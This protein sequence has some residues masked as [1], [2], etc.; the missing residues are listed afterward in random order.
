M[1]P[2]GTIRQRAALGL[3]FALLQANT[4]PITWRL[5]RIWQ[6]SGAPHCSSSRRTTQP[7]AFDFAENE[8]RQRGHVSRLGRVLRK[9]PV[10]LPP[11]NRQYP[12]PP[13]CDSVWRRGG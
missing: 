8:A 9:M 13:E 2:E 11:Q 10:R 3:R 1:F 12:R 6:Q 4:G 5:A 7:L